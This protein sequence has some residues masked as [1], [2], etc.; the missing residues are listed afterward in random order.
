MGKICHA[1]R[2]DQIPLCPQLQWGGGW[3]APEEAGGR[4]SPIATIGNQ[5]HK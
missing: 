2:Y 3:G 5:L 1:S 4:L